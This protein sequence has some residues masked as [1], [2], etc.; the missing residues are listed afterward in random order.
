MQ[1]Q[2]EV[3]LFSEHESDTRYMHVKMCKDGE[4]ENK[5]RNMLRVNVIQEWLGNVCNNGVQSA[6]LLGEDGRVFAHSGGSLAAKKHKAIAYAV[7]QTMID[8]AD[9]STSSTSGV[10][11]DIDRKMHIPET[12]IAD[13]EGGKIIVVV[14][15]P[16]FR[17]CYLC[18]NSVSISLA[19]QSMKL[20]AQELVPQLANVGTL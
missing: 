15:D 7:S 19:V 16:R 13:F 20:V 11:N 3:Y 9:A 12:I 1:Y 4:G 6:L 5:R 14:L 10:L 18:D 2:C 8:Y 17:L